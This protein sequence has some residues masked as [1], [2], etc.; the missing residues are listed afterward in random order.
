MEACKEVQGLPL[1]QAIPQEVVYSQLYLLR[2]G[3]SSLK[4]HWWKQE[5]RHQ[6]Q[7]YRPYQE[8]DNAIYIRM[9]D[10]CYP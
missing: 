4:D 10:G 9:V 3:S 8:G 6:R 2:V 5:G 1:P 7:A